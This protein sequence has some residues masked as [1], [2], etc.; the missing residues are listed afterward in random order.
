RLRSPSSDSSS[1]R[2]PA[3]DSFRP[4]AGRRRSDLQSLR[5]PRLLILQSLAPVAPSPE[6][7]EP[8]QAPSRRFP[9][10]RLCKDGAGGK[11][12]G[13]QWKRRGAVAEAP[14]PWRIVGGGSG[15]GRSDLGVLA[16]VAG[17]RDKMTA[18]VQA[19]NYE[20]IKIF[21]E[22]QNKNR[23]AIL[24]QRIAGNAQQPL[25]PLAWRGG[26]RV[27][28]AAASGVRAQTNGRLTEASTKNSKRSTRP[29]S[30]TRCPIPNSD[31]ISSRE[32]SFPI[33]S[34]VM[35]RDKY[36]NVPFTSKKDKYIK[37][38]KDDVERSECSTSSFAESDFLTR[39]VASDA[40]DLIF[41]F[42]II[43]GWVI[44][45]LVSA[46]LP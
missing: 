21:E 26:L 17:G 34:Y 39:I 45:F 19:Y 11:Q 38:T 14:V 8:A 20:A 31:R 28:Q 24:K 35:F 2:S 22:H 10:T 33:R 5:R 46:S 27:L 13:G 12:G 44:R 18:T 41:F 32:Q 16:E 25:E 4:A 37:F 3:S 9:A 1:L 23:R 7:S 36:A 42:E 30:I 6:F 15:G 43:L 29:R 40:V